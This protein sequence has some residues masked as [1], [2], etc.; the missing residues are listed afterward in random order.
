MRR[1]Y[2]IRA[3]THLSL[4]GWLSGADVEARLLDADIYCT[5][6]L[7]EGCPNAT[8]LALALGLPTVASATG[9]PLDFMAE[10]TH[11]ALAPP[12]DV[13]SFTQALRG[14]V[15]RTVERSWTIDRR[16]VNRMIEALSPDRETT[17]WRRVLCSVV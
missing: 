15:Q 4:A 7:S 13:G 17:A 5:A 10:A 12:G 9:A 3:G 11:V 8:M 14:A 6:T 16:A 1:Q 2:A